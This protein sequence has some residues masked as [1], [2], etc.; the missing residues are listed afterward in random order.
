MLRKILGRHRTPKSRLKALVQ[1]WAAAKEQIAAHGCPIGSLCSELGKRDGQDEV[2]HAAG[3]V[4]GALV[5]I[6]EDEFRQL[7]RRD[8][9]DLAL[10]MVGAYEGAALL[11][12]TLRDPD[13]LTAAARRLDRWIDSI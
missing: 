12:N 8:A 11:A 10:S 13:I 7:G 1:I 2:A 5:T 6:A 9:R 4:L 3:D